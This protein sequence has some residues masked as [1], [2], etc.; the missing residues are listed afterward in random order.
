MNSLLST[1]PRTRSVGRLW[2]DPLAGLGHVAV[3]LVALASLF[4]MH[5]LA[6]HSTGMLPAGHATPAVRAFFRIM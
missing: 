6:D 5:G 3:L 1:P 2:D 4:A